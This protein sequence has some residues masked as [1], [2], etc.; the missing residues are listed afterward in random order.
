M[1]H[2]TYVYA[3]LD[4]RAPTLK[5]VARTSHGMLV[6]RPHASVLHV[7]LVCDADYLGQIGRIKRKAE[8][9]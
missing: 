8:L 3:A 9:F 4:L 2:A 7:R 1:D 6:P 5:E